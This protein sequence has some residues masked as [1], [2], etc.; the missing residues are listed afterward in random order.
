MLGYYGA[1]AESNEALREGWF[2]TGDYG[3]VDG[4]GY[5]HFCGL[6]KAIRKVNGV[7]MDC[8]PAAPRLSPVAAPNGVS[9]LPAPRSLLSAPGEG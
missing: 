4:E 7:T 6:R 1:P 5:L 9:P 2:Y 8:A 3:R